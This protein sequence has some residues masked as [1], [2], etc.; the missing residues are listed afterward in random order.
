MH[1]SDAY[2]IVVVGAGSA[3]AVVARRLVEGGAARV[4]LL[5]AGG[6]DDSPDIH[7][8]GGLFKLWQSEYDWAY[9]T[10][11]QEHHGGRR[12]HWPRGG[13]WAAA[14]PSTA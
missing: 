11:P 1:A 5:E 12:L 2:D 9:F 13:C 6:P 14:A 4:L 7:D 8:P 10:D 3:G